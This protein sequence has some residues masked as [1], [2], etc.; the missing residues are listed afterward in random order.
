[1]IDDTDPVVVVFWWSLLATALMN[2]VAVV[3]TEHG[4]ETWAINFAWAWT[5][6]FASTTLGAL[7]NLASR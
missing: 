4:G 5:G 2:V 7:L 1:M 6:A 3:A